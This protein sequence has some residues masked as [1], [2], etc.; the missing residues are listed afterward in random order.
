ML[1][2]CIMLSSV[3]A[4]VRGGFFKICMARLHIRVCNML[5]GSLVTQEIAFY[6]KKKTGKCM[7]SCVLYISNNG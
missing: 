5:F 3:A 6:D 2:I 7:Y 4:G 1:Y